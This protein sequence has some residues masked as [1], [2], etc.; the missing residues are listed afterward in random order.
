MVEKR[1]YLPGFPEHGLDRQ[2]EGRASWF[3]NYILKVS[4][5]KHHLRFAVAARRMSF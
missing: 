3:L 1:P 2:S 4:S 5:R